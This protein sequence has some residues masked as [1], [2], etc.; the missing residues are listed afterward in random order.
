MIVTLAIPLPSD[1][2]LQD[3][4]D[5]HGRDA[6][7]IAE[8]TTVNSLAKG[9]IWQDCPAWLQINFE[10][11]KAHVSLSVDGNVSQ[12]SERELQSL[13]RNMLGL[14]QPI[15]Q[16]EKSFLS[17]PDIGKLISKKHGL[18]VPQ[19]ASLFE[20]LTWAV[21]GQQISISAAISIRRKFIQHVGITHSSGLLCYPGAMQVS[22]M[23]VE[24]LTALGFS[25]NKAATL[26][27]VSKMVINGTL[28]FDKWIVEKSIEEMSEK[29][30]M[31]KGVGQ[32]TVNYTLLRGLGWLDSSLHGD[33]AVRKRLALL[34]G[35]DSISQEDTKVWLVQFSPWRALVAAHLWAAEATAL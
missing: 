9:I 3:F 15:V 12:D 26:I 18:R 33:V 30:L 10:S 2:I 20:A 24:E 11:N 19:S 7:E 22:E 17:H 6:L 31:I 32:W 29:L 1:F 8:R 16:F 28:P 14:N 25:S 5:F 27:N 13:V 35:K 4:L 34:L 23:T 21:T